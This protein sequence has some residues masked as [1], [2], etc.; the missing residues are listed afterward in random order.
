MADRSRE[1]R[2]SGISGFW[3]FVIVFLAG[4]HVVAD[5]PYRIEPDQNRGLSSA[6]SINDRV[7]L[8]T[9]QVF[10]SGP[11]EQLQKIS[12]EDQ[13][14]DVMN[15]IRQIATAGHAPVLVKLNLYVV[16]EDVSTAILK[17]LPSH[18]PEGGQPA[19][20]LVVTRL[21]LTDALIA[22]DAVACDL[23]PPGQITSVSSESAALPRG[24]RIYISGQAEQSESLAEATMGTLQSL[25]R[26]L[27]FLDRT[28]DDIVQLK[29]FVQPMS[30]HLTVR[31]EV[32]KFF[33]GKTVPP[34]V[35]VEWKSSKTTPIEIELIAAG[36]DAKPDAP[37]MEFLT[38]PGMTTPTVYCRVCRIN[39]PKTIY[40]SGLYSNH[41]RTANPDPAANGDLEVEYIFGSLDRILKQAG[42]DFQH[43]AKA[44]YYVS[45]DAASLSL[46]K[47]RPNYYNPERPPAA[48]KAVVESV[49]ISG[50]GLTLD[51]IA[52]PAESHTK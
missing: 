5:D 20:S 52:V 42:S 3:G 35:L 38:P 46:N 50:L 49:G 51:M 7:L 41:D 22:A 6:V 25:H 30:D 17:S 28:D 45:T 29:V 36:G 24:S 44:T 12:A 19:V 14:K 9:T 43:L 33:A 2:L 18:F 15:Q 1:I 39:S 47:L 10:P 21:P 31:T 26:T 37:A 34:L 4:A 16:S 48:S 13:F 8:H 32:E 40:V 23:R 27:E 11:S